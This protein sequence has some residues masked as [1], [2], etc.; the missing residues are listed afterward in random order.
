MTK[1]DIK[2]L[3]GFPEDQRAQAARLFWE[4]FRGKLAPV[5]RPEDR[6]LRFLQSVADPRHAICALDETGAVVGLAGYKTNRGAFIGG[7]LSDLS[8]AYGGFGG[9]W[10][11]LALSC[12]ERDLQP[13]EL[14]MDGIFVD[15]RARGRGVGTALLRAICVKGRALGFGSVRL[16]VI[17]T[18]PRARAL[19]EREGFEAR[20]TQDLGL[21]RHVFRFNSAT[22]MVRS[23]N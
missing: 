19:Y 20:E 7:S 3:D 16:D 17:D 13:D 22:K 18:N 2:I 12:L 14:Q 8:A 1:N 4:A 6:A 5:M 9:L 15:A 10:R 23:L 21:L 11:G